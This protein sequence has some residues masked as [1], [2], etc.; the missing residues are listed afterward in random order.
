MKNST[1]DT[2]VFKGTQVP[3]KKLFDYIEAG[4]S[5]EEFVADFPDVKKEQVNQVLAVAKNLLNRENL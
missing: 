4:K 1:R 3:I 5:L 2:P